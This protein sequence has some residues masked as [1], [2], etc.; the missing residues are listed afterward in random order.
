[1]LEPYCHTN[2]RDCNQPERT[3]ILEKEHQYPLNHAALKSA[4]NGTLEAKQAETNEF[5]TK[6]AVKVQMQDQKLHKVF[7][8]HFQY[9]QKESAACEQES[10]MYGET[11]T[12]QLE[13]PKTQED[14]ICPV[15]DCE[16]SK[17][18]QQKDGSLPESKKSKRG[19]NT[20]TIHEGILATHEM[21]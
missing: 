4:S 16:D 19:S 14:G 7:K 12:C 11:M 3:L 2:L 20:E 15:Q 6:D 9:S 8:V 1:M 13:K 10:R 18:T 21:A 17:L 5:A